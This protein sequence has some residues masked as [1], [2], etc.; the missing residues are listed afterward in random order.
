MGLSSHCDYSATFIVL[1]L[2]GFNEI[3]INGGETFGAEGIMD[4]LKLFLWGVVSDVFSRS[5][6]SDDLV[7][8][9]MKNL[10]NIFN[11]KMANK[12]KVQ[13]TFTQL[14]RPV[15]GINKYPSLPANNQL[16]GCNNDVNI[17]QSLL[18]EDFMQAKFGNI[19]SQ[20]HPGC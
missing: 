14:V 5:L 9:F 19:H 20:I 1:L 6:T 13:D 12:T 4:Y 17:V 2:L 15:V 18:K 16:E 8:G 3:Y 7:G 11:A 10:F